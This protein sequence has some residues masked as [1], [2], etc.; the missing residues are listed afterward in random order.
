M[1]RTVFS[2]V[3]LESFPPFLFSCS[4]PSQGF[5]YGLVC[6]PCSA[7]PVP[8][9]VALP[10]TSNPCGTQTVFNGV[11]R[12]CAQPGYWINADNSP[13]NPT[14]FLNSPAA[15]WLAVIWTFMVV[16]GFFFAAMSCSSRRQRAL[17][18][19]RGAAR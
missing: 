9:S 1:G 8:A 16:F 10:P 11:R 15:L 4:L 3:A 5:C 14:V 7:G 17:T 13:W 2:A 6:L 19:A 12:V 18:A